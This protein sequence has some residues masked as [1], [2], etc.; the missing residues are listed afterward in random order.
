VHVGS[1]D[2]NERRATQRCVHT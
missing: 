2:M 1:A